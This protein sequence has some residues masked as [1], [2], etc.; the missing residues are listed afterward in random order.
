ME[1]VE[2]NTEICIFRYLDDKIEVFLLKDVQ[3]NYVLPGK[4][5]DSSKDAKEV[6]LELCEEYNIEVEFIRHYAVFDEPTRDYRG[7]VI[8]NAF[9]VITQS[10]KSN[11]YDINFLE[12]KQLKFDHKEILE[13]SITN[14]KKDLLET[15]LAKYFLPEHFTIRMLKNLLIQ[16]CDDY[17]FHRTHFYTKIIKKDFIKPVIKDGIQET[18]IESGAKKPSRLYYMDNANIVTSIYF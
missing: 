8:S 6:A 18:I 11:F 14:I 4:I 10:T 16:A 17:R 7:R 1:K 12:D 2:Y 13:K 5:V 3:N 15:F 9:Y